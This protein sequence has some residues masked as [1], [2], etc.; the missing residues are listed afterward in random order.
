MNARNTAWGW[1]RPVRRADKLITFMCRLSWNLGASTSWNP[2]GLSRPVEGL[3]YL[4]QCS[5]ARGLFRAK[6]YT[7]IIIMPT[8]A[9]SHWHVTTASV[10]PRVPVRIQ[11]TNGSRWNKPHTRVGL[12][13]VNFNTRTLT[14]NTRTHSPQINAHSPSIHAHTHRQYT[15]TFSD[16]QTDTDTTSRTPKCIFSVKRLC[17][18]KHWRHT[19]SKY[20]TKST[21]TKSRQI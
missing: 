10:S 7:G 12:L 11:M 15:H 2:Q 1:R 21:S 5:Y 18:R 3:L 16:R 9:T 19:N 13:L 8:C 14:V 20:I 17:S 4:L 6:H